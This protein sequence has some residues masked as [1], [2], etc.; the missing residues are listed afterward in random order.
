M[1]TIV[2]ERREVPVAAEVDVVVA[3][4]GAAGIAA[5]LAAARSGASVALIER[6]GNLG[7]LGPTCMNLMVF[8]LENP[9][10]IAR[11]LWIDRLL[12]KGYAV[13][14]KDMWEEI[15]GGRIFG[16]SI[17]H[18][19]YWDFFLSYLMYDGERLKYEADR[20]MEEAGVKLFYQ[21]VCPASPPRETR[22]RRRSWKTCPDARRCPAGCSST[23][24]ARA[25]WSPGRA[26]PSCPER[27]S[28]EPPSPPDR[29]T[30]WQTSTWT[31]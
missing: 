23:P 10:G 8:A 14:H 9:R 3:G 28:R 21:S 7:G 13:Y 4:G 24:P 25:T 26:P 22:S 18:A 11:E 1:K 5:A 16:C 12:E 31:R 15:A 19:K 2:E 29:C 30:R 17:G 27:T 20:M 6:F